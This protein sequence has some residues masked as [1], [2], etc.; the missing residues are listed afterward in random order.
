[1]KV[2]KKSYLK[3]KKLYI[4]V[5]TCIYNKL[6]LSDNIYD[7]SK[8]FEHKAYEE[9]ETAKDMRISCNT[10]AIEFSSS[11]SLFNVTSLFLL[12]VG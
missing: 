6:Q 10:R 2:E 3:I 5:V 11:S 12:S 7:F 9:D 1:M 8:D 4:L